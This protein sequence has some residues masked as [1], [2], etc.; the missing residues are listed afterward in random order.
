MRAWTTSIRTFDSSMTQ[1]F[2]SKFLDQIDRG[3]ILDG[4]K[5]F[6]ELRGRNLKYKQAKAK[7]K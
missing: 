5:V 1:V 4:D 3:E 2:V 6:S 7:K